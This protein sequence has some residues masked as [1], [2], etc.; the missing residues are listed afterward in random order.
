MSL[1]LFFSSLEASAHS[2]GC[3]QGNHI[4]FRNLPCLTLDTVRLH[5]NKA[6]KVP[7]KYKILYQTKGRMKMFGNVPFLVDSHFLLS[8]KGKGVAEIAH[9]LHRSCSV[10]DKNWFPGHC[11]Q[12]DLKPGKML[13]TCSTSTYL[14]WSMSIGEAGLMSHLSSLSNGFSV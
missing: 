9:C 5:G 13:P 8:L 11:L 2:C 10:T 6:P 1:F 7:V 14:Y 4:P 12:G 3:F